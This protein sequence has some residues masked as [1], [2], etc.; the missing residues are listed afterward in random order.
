MKKY[1]VWVH[2]E[3]IDEEV[4]HYVDIGE[5]V[6]I[7]EVDDIDT[8]KSIV[9]DIEIMGKRKDKVNYAEIHR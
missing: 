3:E 9:E 4:D 7:T 5:P 6:S 8:A 2:I 1:K